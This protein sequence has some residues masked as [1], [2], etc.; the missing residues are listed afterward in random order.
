LVA[1]EGSSIKVKNKHNLLFAFIY[2]FSIFTGYLGYLFTPLFENI[3]YG[4]IVYILKMVARGLIC[5][6]VSVI[7]H[8]IY[9]KT[10]KEEIIKIEK[11][12]LTLKRTS[13]LYAITVVFITIISIMAGWQLKPL[14]DIGSET[15]TII[16]I[17]EMLCDIG[18]LMIEIYMMLRAYQC[19]DRFYSANN[20][21][22]YKYFTFSIIFVLLTFTVYR[23]IINMS[24]YQLIFVPFTALLGFIYPYTNKSFAKTYLIT[25]LVFLF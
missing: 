14:S 1:F 23:L 16:R 18:V 13:I 17:Y 3:Y 22:S 21:K 2:F 19:F 9:K 10:N 12:N 4:H 11:N 25:I 24:L 15:Y 6:I 20:Y 5:I 8:F 7:L